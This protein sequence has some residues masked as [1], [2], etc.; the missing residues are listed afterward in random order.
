MICEMIWLWI[1]FFVL[2]ILL[3]ALDLGVFHRKAHAFSLREAVGWSLF[4][5]ALGLAFCA[6]VYLIYERHWFGATVAPAGGLVSGGA[7]AVVR[8]LTAYLLE[9][10]LS[11]DNIF[12][13]SML[14]SS[15]RVPARHQHRVLFWG[16]VGALFAR[17]AMI[18]GG[19]WLVHRFT[20]IFYVFGAY[21]G[22]AGVKMLGS[23]HEEGA[24]PAAS[25]SIRLLRRIL[26]IASNDHEHGGRFTTRVDGKF[27]FTELML[28]LVA[29]ELTDVVFAVDSIPA[30]LAI[31]A[32]PF[33]VVTSN[34]FAV[35]GLR[36]LYFILADMITR[37]RYLKVALAG[38][39][40]YIGAKMVLHHWFKI[41]N[42]VSLGVVLGALVLGVIASSVAGRGGPRDR[43]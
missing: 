28:A 40:I 23:K 29:V 34:V 9:K 6:P 16:I 12:V 33:I 18:A 36:S 7:Q 2:I 19:V 5:I 41:P 15:F 20:W 1:G 10:S 25:R 35:L 32:E 4:W 30:V 37:F 13:I 39:L 11:V 43:R 22:Y 3:L 14:F 38:L 8:Y 17:G 31:T 42:L 26:P 24:G 21:L 27:A